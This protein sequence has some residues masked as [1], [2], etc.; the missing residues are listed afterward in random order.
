MNLV[1]KMPSNSNRL[2]SLDGLRAISIVAVVLSHLFSNRIPGGYGVFLFFII[3]GFLITRLMFEELK[4]TGTNSL[5][6]FYQRRF[7]RLYPVIVVYCVLVVSLTP[8]PIREI[9]FM[10][11]ISTLLYFSNYLVPYYESIGITYQMPFRVFWSLS[12][13]EHFYLVFP[14]LFL[15]L[16]GAPRKILILS[17]SVCLVSVSLRAYYIYQM[18]AEYQGHYMSMHTEFRADAISYGV[19]IAALC[20]I[21]FGQ[22]LLRK[23][24]N[25]PAAFAIVI[26]L[27]I[28]AILPHSLHEIFRDVFMG[29]AVM[30]GISAILFGNTFSIFARVLNIAPLVWLGRISYSLYVWHMP[31]GAVVQYFIPGAW[32]TSIAASVGVAAISFYF[33]EQPFIKYGRSLSQKHS[34]TIS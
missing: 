13:E 32:F 14:I 18:S 20:E 9:N 24:D 17:L 21:P 34:V 5:L 28:S 29:V 1:A 30:I 19:I 10:E 22:K 16:R 11:P 27:M 15:I 33:I 2:P 26:L 23:A 31:V 25:F 6:K 12:V 3:S 4:T 7:F 8:I